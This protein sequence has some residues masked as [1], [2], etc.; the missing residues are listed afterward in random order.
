MTYGQKLR[1]IRAMHGL[2]QDEVA[3]LTGIPREVISGLENDHIAPSEHYRRKIESGLGW[4]TFA[5]QAFSLL[6]S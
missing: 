6:A 2:T 5:E 3:Q 1:I 4:P